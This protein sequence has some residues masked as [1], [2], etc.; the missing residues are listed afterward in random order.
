M[1]ARLTLQ[2]VQGCARDFQLQVA[3]PV[4]QAAW[5][6]SNPSPFLTTDTLSTTIWAGEDQPSVLTPTTTWVDYVAGTFQVSV[7]N[8]QSASLLPAAYRLQTTATRAG[9]SASIANCRFEVL[10]AAGSAATIPVYATFEDMLTYAPWIQDLQDDNDEAGFLKE[11]GRARSWL[12]DVIVAR[13]KPGSLAPQLGQPGFGSFFMGLGQSVASD[14]YPT[15]WL[16]DQLKANS[17]VGGTTA[18]ICYDQVI[19]IVSKRAL[20]YVLSAQVSAK[21]ENP[22]GQKAREFRAEASNLAKLLRAEVDMNGDGYADYIINCGAT[23]LR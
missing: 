14:C 19:E 6:D 18:L 16:R 23:N 20:Y 11:R 17:G 12:D 13:Y 9:K 22:F 5:S 10:S 15:K 2:V 21:G 4:N 1:P 3:S 8:S 7:T